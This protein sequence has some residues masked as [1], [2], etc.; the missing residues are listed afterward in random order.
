LIPRGAAIFF[1]VGLV[2]AGIFGFYL[3]QMV[4]HIPTLEYQIGPSLAVITDKISY[5]L[6]EQIHI[7]IINS[8]TVPLTFSDSSYGLEVLRLDGTI[9]FSPLSF[10][11]DAS[12]LKP[13]EEKTF[14]WDQIKS[15]GNKI[16]Q[17]RYNIVSSTNPNGEFVLKKSI[18]INIL[19]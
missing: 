7:R 14:V 12:M 3:I 16:F 15:D 5:H 13:K 6:G 19:T 11:K 2:S 10:T 17:G 18:T 1:V 9:I 8:G 4:N